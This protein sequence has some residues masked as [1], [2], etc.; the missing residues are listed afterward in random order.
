VLFY[1]L[2]FSTGLVS[3]FTTFYSTLFSLFFVYS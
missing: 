1:A 3:F 2:L